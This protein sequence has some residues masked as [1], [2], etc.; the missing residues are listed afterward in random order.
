MRLESLG[1]SGEHE[2]R[3]FAAGER[4]RVDAAVKGGQP[5]LVAD[6][7]SEQVEI[8]VEQTHGVSD[9]RHYMGGWMGVKEGLPNLPHGTSRTQP[10]D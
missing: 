6:G 5:G 2:I 1:M 4:G 8:H 10:G 9:T 3:T 7:M